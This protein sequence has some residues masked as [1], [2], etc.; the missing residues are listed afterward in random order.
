MVG[1]ERSDAHFAHPQQQLIDKQLARAG[2]LSR[3]GYTVNLLDTQIGLVE[4]EEGIAII[5]SFG[6]PAYRSRKVTMGELVDPVVS[7]EFYEISNSGRKLPPETSEFSAFL[8]RYIARWASEAGALW[9]C[10]RTLAA[11]LQ[12]LANRWEP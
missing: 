2:I 3:R 4:A 12:V 6:L 5:P 7:L 8:K 1:A 9:H 11:L 10:P